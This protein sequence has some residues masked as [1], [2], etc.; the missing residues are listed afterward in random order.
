[1]K[2]V[3]YFIN[4]ESIR[5]ENNPPFSIYYTLNEENGNITYSIEDKNG[6]DIN[7]N[8]LNGYEKHYT[9]ICFESFT[10]NTKIPRQYENLIKI[11][12]KPRIIIPKINMRYE[13]F[14]DYAKENNIPINN[15]EYIN[16]IDKMLLKYQEIYKEPI[17]LDQNKFDELIKCEVLSQFVKNDFK[18]RINETENN[19]E[20]SL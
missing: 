3:T 20:E 15:Y 12:E 6:N 10:K 4:D 19:E 8:D 14:K 11:L 2:R 7:I 16:F 13:L 5:N 1:M 9:H 18:E 17:I